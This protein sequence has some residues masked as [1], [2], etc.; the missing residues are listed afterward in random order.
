MSARSLATPVVPP[1]PLYAD[2]EAHGFTIRAYDLRP[3]LSGPALTVAIIPGWKNGWMPMN[4][5]ARG[6]T[7][8]RVFW[9]GASL[10]RPADATAG[11]ARSGHS[12]LGAAGAG[13][14]SRPGPIS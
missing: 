9:S 1:L 3:C 11:A 4:A 2:R 8:T 6:S 10:V 5:C 13:S 7:H 14:Y 12:I